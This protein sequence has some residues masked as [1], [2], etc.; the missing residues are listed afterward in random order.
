M[1]K[2]SQIILAKHDGRFP[3]EFTEVLDLPGIGRYTAGAICSIAF[4]Q[5]TPILDGNVMRV[6]ARLF[7]VSGDPREKGANRQLWKLAGQLVNQAVNSSSHLNQSLMELGA[8]ICVPRQPRC[9]QCPVS[10]HCVA[11]RKGRV[12]ELP[13]LRSRPRATRRRFVAFVSRHK[14]KVFVR[15][16]PA[17]TVNAHL[18]EFPNVEIKPGDHEVG[19]AAQLALGTTDWKLEPFCQIK[20]SITRYRISLDVFSVNEPAARIRG[21]GKWLTRS[22]MARL[23]FCSAHKKILQRL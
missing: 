12:N 23:P 19:K 20:H 7:G 14:G 22:A 2:A 5:P 6:L 11:F 3:E 17:G 15:R 21:D 16:R 10:G 9:G 18:W 13:A 8:L 1:Q 4:N